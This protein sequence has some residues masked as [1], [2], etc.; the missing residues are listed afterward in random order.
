MPFAWSA[1]LCTCAF[2]ASTSCDGSGVG[3]GVG[4]VGCVDGDGLEGGDVIFVGVGDCELVGVV[5]V[6]TIPAE[7]SLAACLHI[8][9]VL[10]AFA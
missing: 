3:V 9:F 7:R 5:L 8:R 2:S 1:R 4:V 10:V 6:D